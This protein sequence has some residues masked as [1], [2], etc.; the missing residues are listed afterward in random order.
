MKQGDLRYVVS[1]GFQG[2][3]LRVARV[4][5]DLIELESQRGDGTWGSFCSSTP[6]EVRSMTR[7]YGRCPA[8]G[9]NGPLVWVDGEDFPVGGARA[10]LY[11][12]D[13]S[14]SVRR[15]CRECTR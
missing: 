2:Q 14:D 8:C 3:V 9:E 13:L 11:G 10:E 15:I 6:D 12:S 1:G 7:E 5:A 4:Y